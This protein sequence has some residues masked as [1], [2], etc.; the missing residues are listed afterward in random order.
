MRQC[1]LLL[2]IGLLLGYETTSS[3]KRESFFS[4][5]TNFLIPLLLFFF[6]CFA[7]DWLDGGSMVVITSSWSYSWVSSSSSVLSSNE[8]DWA[9][10]R[11][12]FLCNF[13]AFLQFL[14]TFLSKVDSDNCW[15]GEGEEEEERLEL[16]R[17]RKDDGD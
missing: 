10:S 16:E 15:C 14:I 8:A 4:G 1:G 9:Y 3:R 6:S 11:R 13:R 17:Q 2:Y 12:F 7:D 5:T